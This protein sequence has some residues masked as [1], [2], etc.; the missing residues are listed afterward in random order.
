M[1]EHLAYLNEPLTLTFE[2]KIVEKSSLPDGAFDVILEQTYFYPT[3]GGQSHDTGTLG[4]R[5][6]L[7]VFKNEAGQ[8]VHRIDGDVSGLVV[9]AKIDAPRRLGNMQHHSAQHIVSWAFESELGL[10]TFS[11]HISAESPSTID[12]PQTELSCADL[13]RVEDA[14]NALIFE[15]RAIKTY[16]VT[17]SEIDDIPLRRP[18]KV[19]GSIRVVEVDGLDYS[20]C[21]GTHCPQTGMIGLIK[22]LHTETVNHKTRVNFVAGR[23]ALDY[24]RRDQQIVSQAA[25]HFNTAP[26]EVIDLAIRQTEQLDAAL[27]TIDGLKGKLLTVEGAELLAAARQVG[28]V[29]LVTATFDDRPAAELRRLLKRLQ[30]PDV[31][32]L[33]ATFDGE[34]ATLLVSCGD[35]TGVN[36]NALL[37]NHLALIDGRGGGNSQL[38]QGGGKTSADQLDVLFSITDT[39]VRNG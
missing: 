27:K 39:W 24:F 33:L 29:R 8:V 38:A 30:A 37:Q 31:V 19:S 10:E 13:D 1:L 26:A 36:A 20:A 16:I 7:D 3:G 6:V 5:R 25:A 2:A 28:A 14:V 23:Q 22:L 11:A 34:K 17:D 9:P 35:K 21:G 18:P 12:I 4:E 32:A 15:N